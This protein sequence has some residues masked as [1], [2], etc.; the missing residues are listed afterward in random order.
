MN[1]KTVFVGIS[2]GVDSSV[3][4]ALLKEEGYNV[5]GVFI[6]TWQPSWM[7]C[8]WKEE[9]R[10]AMR[11]CSTL[12][13][14]FVEI[15]LSEEYKQKVADYMINEYKLGRTPNPDI[16]CN[17]KI[18]FGAFMDWA[19]KNNVD[20]IA[21]GH[22]AQNIFNEKTKRHELH[23]G[24]DA[25]KDQSYFLYTLTN[26]QLKYI[27]FPIGNFKKNKVRELAKKFN[28]PTA[29]KKD[30]QG[31]CFI[32]EV[33]MKEFLSHYIDEKKGDVLDEKGN[34]T[35]THN[36]VLFF[37]LGERHGFEITKKGAEDKPY[38]VIDKDVDKNTITVSITIR[39]EKQGS[40]KITLKEINNINNELKTG[41]VCGAQIRHLGEQFEVEILEVKE[42]ELTFKVKNKKT[43]IAKGQSVVFYQ[44]DKCLGGGV[45]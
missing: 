20:Y 6:R 45:V 39:Q 23:R 40:R 14:P 21:T 31:I 43:L 15:D 24:L 10:D 22:Y 2:G 17:K 7:K 32:G 38:Y 41:L 42:N 4:A 44:D 37:T 3:S 16:M 33:D 1:N 35:G 26:K 25:S 9:R 18:K 30:S 36:G 13:I 8:T 11:V 12:E 27:I 29:T 28:L 19:L 5:V 34:K